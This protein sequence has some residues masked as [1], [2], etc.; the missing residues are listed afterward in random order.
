[1][2]R[3]KAYD[4]IAEVYASVAERLYFSRPARDLAS[5]LRL[6]ASSSVLD[7]GTGSG[8]VS[9]AV[10]DSL[11]ARVIVGTDMAVSMLRIARD[12][13]P[14][15]LFVAS[16]LPA[17]PFRRC[18]FDAATLGFVL[19]HIGDITG[20]LQEIRRVLKPRGQVAFT[21][22]SV[23]P[24]A[25][26]PGRVWEQITHDFIAADE[27]RQATALPSEDR[28]SAP[29]H[30]L[31]ELRAAGFQDCHVEQRSYSIVAKTDEYIDS[32]LIS[33]PSRY[34]HFKLSQREWAGFVVKTRR[35][36]KEEFGENVSF[37]SSVNLALA[38]NAA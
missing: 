19:S 30:L 15:V 38:R 6:S 23:S 3:W 5:L 13:V 31:D 10:R 20:A 22:W 24:G 18:A 1:M 34:L 8:A 33:M 37:V 32:R 14:G 26:P 29:E 28:L 12:H 36:L 25:S 4:G 21:A 2:E 9:A 35:V 16:T 7:V 17:L 11:G 27:L